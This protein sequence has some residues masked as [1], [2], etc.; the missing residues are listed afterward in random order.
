[1]R[2]APQEVTESIRSAAVGMSKKQMCWKWEGQSMGQKQGQKHGQKQHTSRD[3]TDAMVAATIGE[4]AA[5]ERM[6]QN[7]LPS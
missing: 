7:G 3:S 4:A 1:M 6:N 5:A 2:E